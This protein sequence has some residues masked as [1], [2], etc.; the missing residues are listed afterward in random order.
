MIGDS[1]KIGSW[2]LAYLM[3]SKAMT[4]LFVATEI[5]F[6]LSSVGLTYVCSKLFGFEGVSIAHLVNYA[7]Y[8]LVMSY[9]VI[10]QLEAK[11]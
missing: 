8:W 11:Q 3:L 10:K 6:A 9:F 7:L 2:I 4:K 5:L 1:L